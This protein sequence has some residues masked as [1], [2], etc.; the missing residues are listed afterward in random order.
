MAYQPVQD[1]DIRPIQPA[2]FGT[3]ELDTQYDPAYAPAHGRSPS[4]S[5]SPDEESKG[6]DMGDKNPFFRRSRTT[7]WSTTWPLPPP[8]GVRPSVQA[9]QVA[10]LT[11][12]RASLMVFDAVLASTPIMFVALALTA[13]GLDGKE[14]SLYGFK[15]EQTLL[16]SPTIF[17]VIFAALMGRFFRSLGV[18]LAERGTTLGRLEQLFGCQSVFTALERQIT[19]RYWSIVGV[20]TVLIWLLSPVGGQSALRLLSTENQNISSIATVRYLDPGSATTSS[21][22][23]ASSMNSARGTYTSIFL[24]ALLSSSKYQDTS[25]DLWG[26]V[27][28]PLYRDIEGDTTDEWKRVYR[29]EEGGNATYGSLIGVPTIGMPRDGYSNFTIKARQFDITCSRN[30]IQSGLKNESLWANVTG[31]WGLMGDP[32]SPRIGEYPRPILSMSLA[33]DGDTSSNYSVTACNVDYNYFEARVNCNG[34]S[35]G[36]GSMRKL[37]LFGDGYTNDTDLVTRANIIRNLMTVLPRVDNTDVSSP[38]ARGSTNAEKWMADPTNFIGAT[39]DYVQ[40]YKLDPDVF[41]RRL[42]IL[43]N[44]FHQSTFATTTLGGA[45]PSNLTQTGL[46]VNPN[47][48]SPNITFNGTQARVIQQTLP[49][50][51]TNWKWFAALLFSSLIL[52][53][54]AYAGLAIRY[55]TLA[56]DIIGY[57]S[58][59]AMLNPYV[60][61]NTGGS[62]LYGLERSAL[63]HDL[64]VRIGDVRPNEPVGTIAFAKADDGRVAR[65]NRRRY[66][67]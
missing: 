34:T 15:L 13:A 27:K 39:F 31:T 49:V 9:Q 46:L 67:I 5:R 58:S 24:A 6:E 43:W 4:I 52:L 29:D 53:S 10:T 26:N 8:P 22:E 17:P 32:S 66:Y 63:L 55:M 36:V 38:S 19:L 30:E 57:A 21:L 60:P 3:I 41:A 18:Y 33:I 44:T 40:L 11:P 37:D 20:F 35:C 42:T 14:A 12:L 56:P 2:H 62:T 1:P 64:P 59:M 61:I 28:L 50:Y 54:A 25:M 48:F 65:L 23:G 47:G 7:S 16:L 51:K 45:L